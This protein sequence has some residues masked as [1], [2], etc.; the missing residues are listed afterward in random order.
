MKHSKMVGI[1][2]PCLDFRLSNDAKY[3]TA[4]IPIDSIS[5]SDT[6]VFMA[7]CNRD[8]DRIITKDV[9]DVPVYHG[10]GNGF[11][12]IAN[13]ISYCFNLNGPSLTIDTGCSG[14]LVALHQACQS[15]RGGETRQALVGGANLM[16]DPDTTM[17]L[18][19]LR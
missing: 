18:S 9:D 8:Y 15:I 6:A 5:G 1:I 14:S 7:V 11:A 2:H 3:K 13:R 17:S 12:M 16:L 10:T 19:K 4:G